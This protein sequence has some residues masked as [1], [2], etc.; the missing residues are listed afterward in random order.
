MNRFVK[1]ALLVVLVCGLSTPGMSQVRTASKG[2]KG[3]AGNNEGR[4]GSSAAQKG[5]RSK[6]DKRKSTKADALF[7]D[8]GNIQNK[9]EYAL[10]VDQWSTFLKRYA[11][12][13]RAVEARHYRAVCLLQLQ[14]Y[15]L[16]VKDFQRVI[17]DDSEFDF[18]QDTYVNLGWSQY[19]LG[20]AGDAKMFAEATKTLLEF[21]KRHP[22]SKLL[23]QAL[24]YLGESHYLQNK[25]EQAIPFY[26][27]LITDHGGSPLAPDAYYALGVAHQEVD[28]PAEAEKVFDKFLARYAKHNLAGEI[29]TRK[30][31][32]LMTREEF[33]AAEKVFHKA[34]QNRESP[35]ADYAAFRRADA[36]AMQ[37]RY[38]EAAKLFGKIG[39]DF[40]ESRFV[41]P[42]FVAA[43]RNLYEAGE[44]DQAKTW[45]AKITKKTSPQFIEREHWNA[46]I[47]LAQ[48]DPSGA[49][50]LAKAALPDA[51]DD[52]MAAALTLD[53]AD[54]L[55]MQPEKRA[56][57]LDLYAK[58]YTDF[59]DTPAA[60]DALY[61]ASYTAMDL[62]D[63]AQAITLA[64]RFQED[65][66][67]HKLV[68]DSEYVIAE[69][70][71]LAKEFA[72]AFDRFNQ[73][74]KNY[75]DH[76]DRETWQLR[77]GL[78]LI[79]QDKRDEAHQLITTD[80]ST[81]GTPTAKA[82]A[83]YL[84]GM[85]QIAQEKYEAAL[86]SLKASLKS[87]SKWEK[88]DEVTI[89]LAKVQRKLGR[90]EEALATS[91]K[92]VQ[93]KDNVQDTALFE[94]AEAAY[95]SDNFEESMVSYTQLIE[96]FP[97]SKLVP[98]ALYGKAWSAFKL[99]NATESVEA[100][101]H[102]IDQFAGH[103]LI[104]DAYRTRAMARQSLKQFAQAIEDIAKFL[105]SDPQG[106]ERLDGLYIQGLCEVGLDKNEA[107]IETFTEI[108]SAAPEYQR[109]DRVLYEL[110]WAQKLTDLD[111]AS[112]KSFETLRTRFPQSKLATEAA[113]HVGERHYRDKDYAAAISAYQDVVQGTP[114]KDLG[115]KAYYKLGW[116]NFKAGDFAAARKMFG[117]QIE[118]HPQGDL[119]GDGHFM[120]GESWFQEKKYREA[121]AAYQAVRDN[122]KLQGRSKIVAL[123]HGGQA[124]AQLQEWET[125]A[126]WLAN[127]NAKFGDSP[128]SQQARYEEGRAR[129]NLK[130]W[131]RAQAL[132]EK[133]IEESR[134]ETGA[135]ARFM[136][137]ELHF[138]Q[139][140]FDLA[141][142][143]FQL[144]V[145]GYGGEKAPDNIR[146]WQGKGALE[147]GRVAAIQ[148]G[149]LSG[150]ER[151]AM[152]ARAKKYFNLVIQ[153][154]A[155][156][157]EA[158]AAEQQL[159]KLGS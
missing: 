97:K 24:F 5:T 31:E 112:I 33:A 155:D 46:R 51:K 150:T 126:Q 116:S 52:R 58:V 136:L 152:I 125:S 74:V 135:R 26:T 38:T 68:P 96:N 124:A 69:S 140:Q 35:L 80:L 32:T 16:A 9:G 139:K 145:L 39:D 144:L 90:G 105:K 25:V 54:A 12:D 7:A 40:Q 89:S 159:K 75:E 13:H 111:D 6:N 53:L 49:Y 101:T 18:I 151:E 134:N 120:I 91:Q 29:F 36:V 71:F 107:A 19:S 132:Y 44:L 88:A 114:R 133:V 20:V 147:A 14:K 156:T 158:S 87:S 154:H 55:Y 70:A 21:R 66:A 82:E 106:T 94:L 76:K 11:D 8:A 61:N 137:G 99:G 83:Y 142:K 95:L 113:Y 47:A 102:L 123:L 37:R 2:T 117:Q 157:D 110:A 34:S 17:E 121:F 4:A 109:G 15:E 122:D 73:L 1:L 115:E 143:Q 100:T 104:P 148:A 57:S 64:K 28:Q 103:E 130:Q 45:L 92:L 62:E 77:R 30:G 3:G 72:A 81:L 79:M 84:L 59:A 67:K 146:K 128:Y 48:N 141:L 10:A 56:E 138:S 78:C 118:D 86:Q 153:Q 98:K 127:L 149:Q 93:D 27:E 43:G 131:D 63:Y 65:F 23:D 42:S 108:A 119:I 50:R 129:Q 22:D 85:N 41:E 60:A